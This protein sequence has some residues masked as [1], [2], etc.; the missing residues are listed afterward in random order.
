MKILVLANYDMGLY[1]FRK[2]L[3][4]EL[5]SKHEVH[6]ALPEGQYVPLLV[7]MG[8][9]FHCVHLNR[10]GT[11]ILQDFSLWMQYLK[12]LKREKP[13]VV[14]TYTIKPNIYG[15]IACRLN[16]VPYMANITGLGTAMEKPGLFHR[17]L[18]NL[19]KTG[20]KKA[21]YVFFQNQSN[22][23][24]MTERKAVGKKQVLLPGSGV[25]LEQH[26]YEKYPADDKGIIFL[27][28]GRLMRDKGI[29]EFVEAAKIIKNRHPNVCFKAV[30]FCEKEYEEVLRQMQAEKYV[31]LC[32]QQ[33]NVHEYMKEASAVVL[34]SY[35]EGMA[36]VLLEGAACGRPVL[37][38]KIPGC[39][40]TFE[41]GISGYGFEPRSVDSLVDVLEQFMA[42][43]Y[44]IREKMGIEGRKKVERQFDRRL[45]I[46]AYEKALE[47]IKER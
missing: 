27:F 30:G 7:D 15:G 14:F 29:G 42:L 28:V 13:D 31:M 26:C 3:L 24:F 47:N 32:G 10:R 43:D 46:N 36:N 1:K 19:Y 33:D 45:I 21:E 6:I 11:N 25:N 9:V 41:E 16:K 23:E 4:K 5:I 18:V 20:I 2:E 22:M 37:A 39:E 38:S 12:L 44:K 40:E 34:P 35:H 8:C 17:L